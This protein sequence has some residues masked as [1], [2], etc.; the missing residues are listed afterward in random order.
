MSFQQQS[1][2]PSGF[3]RHSSRQEA[4][5][6][7]S[8]ETGRR[9]TTRWRSEFLTSTS[10]RISSWYDI[11]AFERNPGSSSGDVLYCVCKTPAGHW[12]QL[13]IANDEP[14]HPLRLRREISSNS[15]TCQQPM[16][17][18]NACSPLHYP[19]DVPWNIGFIPSSLSVG[20]VSSAHGTRGVEDGLH[21]F[22]D[23][24]TKSMRTSE[25]QS[26]GSVQRQPLEVIEIGAQTKKRVGE[27]YVVKPLTV[28][29][30]ERDGELT[31]TVMAID[32]SDPMARELQGVE[33]VNKWLPGLVGQVHEWLRRCS[34]ARAGLPEAS[35]RSDDVASPDATR[36]TILLS[37]MHWLASSCTEASRHNQ[38]SQLPT[39]LREK[40]ECTEGE[41]SRAHESIAVNTILPNKVL[42]C[43]D[44]IVLPVK[45]P[46]QPA[47]EDLFSIFD[48]PLSSSEDGFCGTAEGDCEEVICAGSK[49]VPLHLNMNDT[50]LP[51]DCDGAVPKGSIRSRYTAQSASSLQSRFRHLSIT[52]PQLYH[53]EVLLTPSQRCTSGKPPLPSSPSATSS[54]G[55]LVRQM[56][57]DSKIGL[58]L[59]NSPSPKASHSPLA[60]RRQLHHP[61]HVPHFMES[62][63]SSPEGL[64]KGPSSFS[65]IS[66][67][68]SSSSSYSLSRQSSACLSL[69]RQ[70]SS[71]L[72]LPSPLSQTLKDVGDL[73]EDYIPK[74]PFA[75]VPSQPVRDLC[76]EGGKSSTISRHH[77]S[78][79]RPEEEGRER[80]SPPSQERRRRRGGRRRGSIE[81]PQGFKAMSMSAPIATGML[82]PELEFA[83]APPSASPSWFGRRRPSLPSVLTSSRRIG[84]RGAGREASSSVKSDEG[85]SPPEAL[86]HGGTWGQRLRSLSLGS[87]R[88][89]GRPSTASAAPPSSPSAH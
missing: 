46:L 74:A 51:E 28:F 53:S 41:D 27:I 9:G 87:V 3:Q 7:F 78:M 44:D 48:I 17:N 82:P 73:S 86:C 30:V 66:R 52:N 12:L 33:D 19:G 29:S 39:I 43:N 22:Q 80:I 63:M 89:G 37:H 25:R 6:V 4:S 32:A 64:S 62:E 71:S 57:S 68:S 11:P 50:S 38:P 76:H 83:T 67:Q 61:L 20:A 8:A 23:H 88:G 24:I 69:S 31:W 81:R 10:S 79:T 14:Y 60:A 42:L 21:S 26:V 18:P 5:Y 13:E 40:D 84:R 85:S 72:T 34:S 56:S 54:K 35:V 15:S 36:A 55:P 70:S 75:S 45:N 77:D 65:S 49:S 2:V 59:I 47:A 16:N 1:S 58:P